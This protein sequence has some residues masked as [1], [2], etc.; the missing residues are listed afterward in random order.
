MFIGGGGRI[1][2]TQATFYADS[3]S[4]PL[5]TLASKP[6]GGEGAVEVGGILSPSIRYALRGLHGAKIFIC[7][8]AKN[9]Y[10]AV[11]DTRRP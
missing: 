5:H 10:C 11:V 1:F 4:Q 2:A 8:H 7:M 3:V 9:L 6:L